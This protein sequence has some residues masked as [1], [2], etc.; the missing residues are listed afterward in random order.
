MESSNITSPFGDPVDWEKVDPAVLKALYRRASSGSAYAL[1]GAQGVI[2]LSAI[3][4]HLIFESLE[5]EGKIVSILLFLLF[6]VTILAMTLRGSELPLFL[7]AELPKEIWDF[8]NEARK[9]D[10]ALSVRPMIIILA[11]FVVYLLLRLSL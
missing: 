5:G 11:Q 7:R 1:A 2:F 4:S 3:T 10:R 8:Q 9:I 6:A